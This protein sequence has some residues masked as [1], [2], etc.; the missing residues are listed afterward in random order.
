MGTEMSGDAALS[1]Y[2]KF[3]QIYDDFNHQNN[4][5][6]WLGRKLLPELEQRG[7]RQGRVL[8]VG[9]GTGRA[10]PPLL[11]RGWEIHGCDLSPA[12]LERAREQF[13]DAVRLDVA[14]MRELPVFGE[15]ELVL[16]MNDAV[17]YLL[18]E[19]DLERAL[20]AIRPNLAPHGLLLFDT[21]S[22]LMYRLA[23]ESGED[24]VSKNGRSWTWTGHGRDDDSVPIYRVEITGDEIEPIV[25]E[26][27][28]FRIDEVEAALENAG[29]ERLA[30]LGQRETETEVVL[31]EPPDDEADHKIVYISRPRV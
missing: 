13:G 15:F 7:L 3:A 27:R 20:R 17:N 26:E 5:E 18:G 21:N 8:D 4:Y 6:M 11:K 16:V 30:V 2:E 23:Y 10:F 1:T 19:G 29:Y 25:N 28:Y 22:R 31:R 12:M 24:D 9:C 14:D